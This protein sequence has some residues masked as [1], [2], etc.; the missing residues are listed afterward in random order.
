MIY[1]I[2]QSSSVIYSMHGTHTHTYIYIYIYI[3]I[4]R[5]REREREKLYYSF[6]CNGFSETFKFYFIILDLKSYS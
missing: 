3:Y 2:R 4:Y 1:Y 5:E 6:T